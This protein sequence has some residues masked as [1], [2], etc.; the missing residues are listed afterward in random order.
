MCAN[1]IHYVYHLGQYIFCQRISINHK[2]LPDARRFNYV[3]LMRLIFK[4][5]VLN[6]C[7]HIFFCLTYFLVSSR[8]SFILYGSFQNDDTAYY[9][10][11]D[12]STRQHSDLFYYLFFILDLDF[13]VSRIRDA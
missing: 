5:F 3:A 1:H 7:L 13:S 11:V 9:S 10:G 12:D 4:G 2:A 6:A 8:V